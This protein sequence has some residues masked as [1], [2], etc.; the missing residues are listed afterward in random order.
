M[1]IDFDGLGAQEVINELEN[2][3]YA[4]DCIRPTVKKIETADIGEWEDSNPLNF[5]ATQD[6][7]FNNLFN[8]SKTSNSGSKGP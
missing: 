3:N 5:K 6:E 2:S 7:A 8:G 4:N 1:I